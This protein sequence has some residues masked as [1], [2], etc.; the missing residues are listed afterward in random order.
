MKKTGEI[1]IKVT[2]KLGHDE[3]SPKNFDI[4]FI[5][6][7]LQDVEH[8]LYPGNKKN[9]PI[10]TYGIEE[11]SVRNIF[12]TSIQAIIMFNAIMEEVNNKNSIDFLE[13]QT[14]RAFEN[15]QHIAKQK[16]FSFHFK[17]S[18]NDDYKLSITPKTKFIRNE[19]LWVDAEF[20]FYGILT[21]A[22]GKNKTNIHIDTDEY[23]TI[24]INTDRDFLKGQEKNLLYKEF[25][26]RAIG[27]QNIET[28]EMDT[29]TL[30]LIEL[31]NYKPDFDKKYLEDLIEKAK[32]TWKGID[33][34]EWIND[35][36]G[37]YEA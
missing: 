3:L 21:N 22:G 8:L 35:I 25:G 36:R 6:A 17:T 16:N 15:I 9:R 31:I 11:G 28:G 1:E 26:V 23:G 19:K 37:D 10:I 18:L 4:K 2:G 24:I 29:K 7:L 12:R 20:Y 30:K 14:A 34:N 27:K 33:A 32:K 13:V 5:T